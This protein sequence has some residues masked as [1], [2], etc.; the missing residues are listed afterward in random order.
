MREKKNKENKVGAKNML[1]WQSRQVSTT[2]VV[3]I[4]AYL[5]IYC[6]DTLQMPAAL[7]SALLVASKLVDG[8]TDIFAGYIVDR[9]ETR[10]G[11]GRPYEVFVILLWL[12]TWLMFSC[13]PEFSLTLKSV[14]VFTMYVLVNAVSMTFLNANNTVYVTRAFNNQEKYVSISSY[15]GIIT[16]FAAVVFNV[17]FPMLMGKMATSPAGWSRLVGMLAVPL[18]FIGILRMLTIKEKYEVETAAG[19]KVRMK[20]AVTVLKNNPYIY[21]IAFMNFVFNFVANMGVTVYY[22]TYI[23]KD[24]SLMGLVSITNILILPSALAFPKLI[25]KFS[26]A[27][28]SMFGFIIAAFGYFINTFAGGNVALLIIGSICFGMGTVPASMLSNLLI[29]DCAEFNEWKGYRRLE[30]TMSS[31][32]GLAV[33]VGS[34]LGA[35]VLGILLSSAGYTG[36]METMPNSA[37]TMIR[38]LFGAIPMVLYLIT[39][40]TLLLYKLDKILPQ[41]REENE[42]NRQARAESN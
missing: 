20:D 7:V 3:L 28:V 25:S 18:A 36:V 31:I 15:G 14:W 41:V 24:V 32:I 9:T 4:T 29:I 13:P 34:A 21:I 1:L 42:K 40:A 17:A 30:G 39:A 8:I 33:K 27:K 11:K 26:T 6:T 23:V 37:F 5:M 2:I 12:C 22:Y 35:G 16:M 38:L 19:E 10:W